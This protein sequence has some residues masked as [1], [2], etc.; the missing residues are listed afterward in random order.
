MYTHLFSFRFFSHIDYHRILGSVLCA[1]Q[2]VPGGQSFHIPQCADA[3]P[4][5]LIH[6]TPPTSLHLSPVVTTVF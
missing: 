2:Q 1:L 3:S 5:A 4:K 6:S